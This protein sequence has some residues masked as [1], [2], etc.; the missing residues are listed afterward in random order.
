MR[1]P[2]PYKSSWL[3]LVLVLVALGLATQYIWA[4]N[5][6]R[7][8]VNS[9]GSFV[10]SPQHADHILAGAVALCRDGSQ[11]FSRH[12]WGTCNYHGGVAR[13]L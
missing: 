6:L 1:H 3:G 4:V 12:V 2:A 5:P 8:Y 9:D 13:W 11:S 7:G 10:L